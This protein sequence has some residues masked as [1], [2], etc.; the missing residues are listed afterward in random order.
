MIKVNKD[1]F[2]GFIAEDF[3]N[4]VD[5]SVFQGGL[6]H[7]DVTPVYKKKDKS[8]KTNY[9]P[10]HILTN[11]SKTYGKLIYNQYYDYFDDI[12]FDQK[13]S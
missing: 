5:E 7:A 8:D 4:C 9:R 6:K 13:S 11:I 1:I 12:P 10:V 2:A 3:N